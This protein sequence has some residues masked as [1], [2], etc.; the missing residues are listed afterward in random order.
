MVY[1]LF[2]INC[3]PKYYANKWAASLPLGSMQ[4]YS[5]YSIVNVSPTCKLAD[6]PVTSAA[7]SVTITGLFKQTLSQSASERTV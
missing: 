3:L 4:P 6:V 1:G 5:N 2:S 7:S